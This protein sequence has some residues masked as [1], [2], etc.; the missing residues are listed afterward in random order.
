MNLMAV[1]MNKADLI[2]IRQ[3]N[4]P[5]GVSQLL[6]AMIAEAKGVVVRDVEGKEFLDFSGGIGVLNVGH[7]PD[8]VVEAVCDQA[9]K[10]LHS[11]FMVQMYESYISLAQALNETVAGNYPKKTFFVNSGAEA[12]ENAVKIA[13]HTLSARASYASR[14]P[15]TAGRL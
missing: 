5:R 7:C 1:K 15:S 14:M 11:C 4:V 10:Y 12:V 13:R 6:P 3:D 9:R 8:A 2:K